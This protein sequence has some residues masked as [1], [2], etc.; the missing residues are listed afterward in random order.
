MSGLLIFY[1]TCVVIVVVG[2]FIGCFFEI[3]SGEEL[4]ITASDLFGALLMIA[5]AP[6]TLFFGTFAA[7]GHYWHRPI[8]AF[9]RK[10]KK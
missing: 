4:S 1:L 6:L 9:K 5:I 7:I 8:I 3:L 10:E 2:L